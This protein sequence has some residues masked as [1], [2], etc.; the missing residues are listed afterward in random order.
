MSCSMSSTVT[1]TASSMSQTIIGS[2]RRSIRPIEM[3]REC[4]VADMQVLSGKLGRPLGG[5]P[6][7]DVGGA[8]GRIELLA[9][10]AADLVNAGAPDADLH[11]GVDHAGLQAI[12][13]DVLVAV[14]LG[15][16]A[17]EHGQRRLGA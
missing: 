7:D 9:R 5:E 3:F 13:E 2:C 12:S 16:A 10:N 14:F 11:L 15:D 17:C 8:L 6:R 4:R 1:P